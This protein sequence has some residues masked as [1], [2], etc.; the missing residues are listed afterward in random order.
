MGTISRTALAFGLCGS[1]LWSSPPPTFA[2][3]TTPPASRCASLKYKAAGRYAQAIAACRARKVAKGLLLV[4]QDCLLKART[5][6]DQAFA[7]AEKKG[8]CLATGDQDYAAEETQAY[9]ATLPPILEGRLRC[10]TLLAAD[11]C[12]WTEDEEEC[13]AF[14]G[15]TLGPPGS[16]CDG[17][18]G[19]CIA[20]PQTVSPGLCCDGME[21]EQGNGCAG[22]LSESDCGIAG[23]SYSTN[24]VCRPNGACEAP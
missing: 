8:D 5:K 21:L 13:D 7:R 18:T 6:L 1:I 3:L 23:G 15:G 20:P 24:K 19:G 12:T 2:G 4:E 14:P 11:Q 22:N 17:P 10:C 16:F 9:L